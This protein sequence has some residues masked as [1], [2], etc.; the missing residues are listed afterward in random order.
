MVKIK[1]VS[2]EPS[3]Y[4]KFVDTDTVQKML[5]ITSG[6]ESHDFFSAL[7]SNLRESGHLDQIKI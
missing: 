7:G 5:E 1:V 6:K 4:Y 3:Y 2:F